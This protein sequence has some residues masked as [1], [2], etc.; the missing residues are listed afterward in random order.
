MVESSSLQSLALILTVGYINQSQH[1]SLFLALT[2]R[3]LCLE[4]QFGLRKLESEPFVL[5][6]HK[7]F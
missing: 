7:V 6:S 4:T 3:K 5:A 1:R 2:I